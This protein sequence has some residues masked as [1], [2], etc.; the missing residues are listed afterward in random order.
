MAT[1]T[2]T[3]NT[4]SVLCRRLSITRMAQWLLP[5]T[6]KRASLWGYF[7]PIVSKAPTFEADL[8]S[9]YRHITRGCC[10]YSY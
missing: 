10:C 3:V 1:T 7:R 4:Q 5:F 8:R 9:V 2:A 6:N